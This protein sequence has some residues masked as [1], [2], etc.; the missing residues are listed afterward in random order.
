VAD[1]GDFPYQ[2]IELRGLFD[3]KD[4]QIIRA[5][6][7]TIDRLANTAEVTLLDE[8]D[9]DD[10]LDLE[11]VP[12]FYHCENSTGTV[13]DLALGHMAF[14][15]EDMVYLLLNKAN[16]ET[17]AQAFIIGHV[18]IK[19]T[20][21]CLDPEYLV[22]TLALTY[23]G[24]PHSY[25]TIYD[26][27]TGMK[28][29]LAS[30]ENLTGS[31]AKPASFPA[32]TSSVSSW[33]AYN[34]EAPIPTYT[35]SGTISAVSRTTWFDWWGSLVDDDDITGYTGQTYSL[36][37][38]FSTGNG[39]DIYNQ[40]Q[41]YTG[42]NSSSNPVNYLAEYKNEGVGVTKY[43]LGDTYCR[44]YWSTHSVGVSLSHQD[45]K[46][47]VGSIVSLGTHALMYTVDRFFEREA[48]VTNS[49]DTTEIDSSTYAYTCSFAVQ[50]HISCS[51]LSGFN[52]A[53]NLTW[54]SSVTG[55]LGLPPAWDTTLREVTRTTDYSS[56]QD[57]NALPDYNVD[58][59][60]NGEFYRLC[61][62]LTT[63]SSAAN[64]F[65]T[66]Y[67]YVYG[68]IGAI[69][70]EQWVSSAEHS[71][72]RYKG[73][74]A[75]PEVWPAYVEGQPN[76]AGGGVYIKIIPRSSAVVADI[77]KDVAP[78]DPEV[79]IHMYDCIQESD[80]VRAA[81]LN[82]T[83]DELITFMVTACNPT[84]ITDSQTL[85]TAIRQGPSAVVRRK[86]EE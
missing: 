26:A 21:K 15:D 23:K 45:D 25:V 69:S 52:I 53:L 66:G 22:V 77:L 1:C 4:A 11:A 44:A 51:T 64:C 56:T 5:E 37:T 42:N 30:F 17:P 13:E 78:V 18:D 43:E 61:P 86:K 73:Y 29:D 68:L 49:G 38:T 62:W 59:V 35:L 58:T 8:C 41:S 10:W 19:G 74:G 57:L 20:K 47:Q 70:I 75:Y 76:I 60:T 2:A 12:F 9:F 50:D 54:S 72:T 84:T 65:K 63:M 40:S 33:L 82:N 85:I 46:I 71:V 14:V 36:C 24:T 34:R 55:T 31:P 3:L 79:Y 6:I 27:S 39:T 81:G 48:T 67:Y 16:G 83:I 80:T 7:V 28:M 32:A